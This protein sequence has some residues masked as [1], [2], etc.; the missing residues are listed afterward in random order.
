MRFFPNEN[1]HDSV[2]IIVP[3]D[4]ARKALLNAGLESKL[5]EMDFRVVRGFQMIHNL[6]TMAE[7]T[8]LWIRYLI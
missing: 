8:L 1:F 4:D 2:A 6:T 5:D 7:I 3:N